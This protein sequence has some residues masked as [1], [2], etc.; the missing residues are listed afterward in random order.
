[1]HGTESPRAVSSWVLCLE[2]LTIAHLDHHCTLVSHQPLLYTE[3]AVAF[4]GPTPAGSWTLILFGGSSVA[5]VLTCTPR[6]PESGRLSLVSVCYAFCLGQVQEL[7][8][9]G[10]R[11]VGG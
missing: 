8:Y 11:K 5:S 9:T 7:S 10:K 6:S 1:M 3:C 4:N 2:A